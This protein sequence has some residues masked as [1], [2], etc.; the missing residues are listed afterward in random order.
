M[1]KLLVHAPSP[2]A[3]ELADRGVDLVVMH[4]PHVVASLRG[5]L[6]DSCTLIPFQ[7]RAKVD[8]S[9]V[10]AMRRVLRETTPGI[11][12]AFHPKP[13]ASAVLAG[14]GLPQKPQIVSFRGIASVPSYLDAGNWVTVLNPAVRFHTCE[15]DA[16]VDGLT[17]AGIARSSCHTVYN[18]VALE[19][20]GTET[21]NSLRDRFGIPRDAFVV[22]TVATI[23]PVKGID[24]LIKAAASCAD[25][26]DTWWLIAGPIRDPRVAALAR[27]P[28]LAGR[29]VMPGRVADG[30]LI[31]GA[32]DLFV[33]PSR[34]EALCRALL[35]A[36]ARA[37]CPVV[38]DAGGM[39]EVVRHGIDGVVVPKENVTALASAI[40][41]LHA[42]RDRVLEYTESAVIRVNTMC[43][44]QAMA[45]RVL[46]AHRRACETP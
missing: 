24:L 38:S 19:R 42:N 36:M 43:S 40:R 9:A 32:L 22:G 27:D 39:K 1:K 10:M 7:P 35:E 23:R 18:C 46:E 17:R 21:R 6:P 28:R 16:V 15:S 41:E 34:Q 45:D 26:R 14:I 4:S 20:V 31:G 2:L 44:P 13:L 11:V 37:T 33:M 8:P 5:R 25:L 3:C 30:N 12:H 29:L